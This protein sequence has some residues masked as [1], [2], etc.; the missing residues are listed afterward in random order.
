MKGDIY[1]ILVDYGLPG[2]GSRV[3]QNPHWE[4]EQREDGWFV[5]ENVDEGRTVEI[6]PAYVLNVR[7]DFGGQG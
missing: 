4:I 2:R 6:N 1:S 3:Y 7:R 5:A